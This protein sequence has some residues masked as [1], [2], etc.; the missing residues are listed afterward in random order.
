[1]QFSV[2]QDKNREAYRETNELTR[3]DHDIFADQLPA[4]DD[5]TKFRLG[6]LHHQEHILRHR[7][8]ELT[9]L[10]NKMSRRNFQDVKPRVQYMKRN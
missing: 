4:A 10:G 9:K 5:V 8:V 6:G 1:M 7:K 3:A 2:G